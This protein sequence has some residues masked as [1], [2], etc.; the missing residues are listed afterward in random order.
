LELG[1]EM[2][3]KA[4][5]IINFW[6]SEAIRPL[7]FAKNLDLDEKIRLRYADLHHSAGEG[8]LDD[9]LGSPQGVLALVILLDQFSR[10][11]FRGSPKAF[12]MDSKALK[13]SKKAILQG[14]DQLLGEEQRLFL[15]MPF[16]HSETLADQEVGLQLFV[17]GQSLDYARAHRDII[18]R[19]GRFP[20]RNVALG[21]V[22][23]PEE[24][25]FLKEPGS[26]F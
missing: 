22:S 2:M 4:E 25:E 10:N 23:T 11:L 16:M 20:H 14:F 19:F 1:V 26:S 8:L 7:W 17:V 18:A 3:E 12:S 9:W 5:D 6:F 15:Y 13:I 21:R 24:V